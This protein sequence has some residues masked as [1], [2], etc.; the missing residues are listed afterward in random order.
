SLF[1]TMMEVGRNLKTVSHLA[2]H[3]RSGFLR[4][5]AAGLCKVAAVVV[6]CT[7][8]SGVI[9]AEQVRIGAVLEQPASYHLRTVHMRGIV[10]KVIKMDQL[11]NYKYGGTCKGAYTFTLDDST[12][13]LPIEVLSLCGR[14]EDAIPQVKE[15]QTVSVDA[16]IEAPGYYTGQGRPLGEWVNSI[17]AVAVKVYSE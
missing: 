2:S 8:P 11:S 5:Y 13:V 12:G 16:R 10:S 9:A 4:G 1:S 14:T 15:G 7:L 17:R 6:L 3:P